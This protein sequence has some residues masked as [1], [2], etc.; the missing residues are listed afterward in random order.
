MQADIA[1]IIAEKCVHPTNS[2]HFTLESI[3]AA[4]K[5]IHYPVKLDQPAKRQALECIKLLQKRYKLIRAF[6]KIR[7]SFPKVAQEDIQKRLEDIEIDHFEGEE[8]KEKEISRVYL[9]EPAKYR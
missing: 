7:I 1:T 2:R 4:M 8:I 9:I 3:K 5:E 6:M